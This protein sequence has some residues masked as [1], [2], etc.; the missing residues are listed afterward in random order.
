MTIEDDIANK[1]E[2]LKNNLVNVNEILWNTI[3]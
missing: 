1:E 3:E 2:D